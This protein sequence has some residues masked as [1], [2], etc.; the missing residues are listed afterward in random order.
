M[1]LTSHS[2]GVD[3]LEAYVMDLTT[4]S[5]KRQLVGTYKKSR[6]RGKGAH[7]ARVVRLRTASCCAQRRMAPPAICRRRLDGP[8]GRPSSSPPSSWCTTMYKKLLKTDEDFICPTDSTFNDTFRVVMEFLD[9]K[10]SLVNVQATPSYFSSLISSFFFQKDMQ[11]D[12]HSNVTIN[13]VRG[14]L[15]SHMV[16][17]AASSPDMSLKAC[18]AL[19]ICLYGT[20]Q[21]EVFLNNRLEL[22]AAAEKYNIADLNQR[23][24]RLL[25]AWLYQ[26][27][28]L[29]KG[30]LIFRFDLGKFY[31][32]SDDINDSFCHSDY[33]QMI[34]LF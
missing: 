30:S 7:G 25:E 5:L 20:I 13:T 10:M 23:V 15:L 24:K 18:Y 17:L 6:F 8:T 14:T 4:P 33:K 31:D 28:C 3:S 29:K 21:L 2:S 1:A 34:E 22:L 19:L 32:V 9:L 16:V 27:D 11:T 26:L 12:F